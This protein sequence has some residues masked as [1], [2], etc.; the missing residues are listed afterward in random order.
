MGALLLYLGRVGRRRGRETAAF[1]LNI[2]RVMFCHKL[3][4]VHT[5]TEHNE[6]YQSTEFY[7]PTLLPFKDQVL[8]SC[9]LWECINV[10]GSV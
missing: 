9:T 5:H 4:E 1:L 2:K 3:N 7:K 6:K 8:I 10:V